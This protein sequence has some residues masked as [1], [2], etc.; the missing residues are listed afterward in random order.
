MQASINATRVFRRCDWW[1]FAI[2]FGVVFTVYC[3][4]LSSDIDLESSGIFATA[5][6]HEGVGCPP[7]YPQ[8][9]LITWLFVHVL[10]FGN[11][12]WRISLSSALEAA[13]ASGLIALMGSKAGALI[14]EQ[15]RPNIST[16]DTK[17]SAVVSGCVGAMALAFSTDFWGRAITVDVEPFNVLLFCSVLALSMRWMLQPTERRYLYAAF[18]IYGLTIVSGQ[19]FISTAVGMQFL[20]AFG[21]RA[22][23]RDLLLSNGALLLMGFALKWFGWFPMLQSGVLT[24]YIVVTVITLVV[25]AILVIATR[26]AF[27]EWRSVIV[28]C[29]LMTVATLS[30]FIVPVLS[31]TNPPVNWAY[32]RTVEGFFHLLMRGQFE[33]LNPT[34]SPL[35]LLEQLK[36]FAEVAFD[37]FGWYYLAFV[38][39]SL[40]ILKRVRGHAR[41]WMLSNLIVLF[42]TTVLMIDVLN[43]S[44]D[45]QS[46]GLLKT[47]FTQSYVILSVL[48]AIGLASVGQKSARA[49]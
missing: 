41:A 8:W 37:D 29:G 36:M 31:M 32:P 3:F 33:R 24:L 35:R 11:I 19:S 30:Y 49:D 39:A 6:M 15:L 13:L 26:N 21:E 2:T 5:A 46:L 34:A 38:G 12:A 4:T 18:F 17:R 45:R 25:A 42:S 40:N 16:R 23:G 43:V 22:L 44:A 10:P 20:V 9:T 7:G 48:T 28:A 1:A 14:T 47:Y 27:S